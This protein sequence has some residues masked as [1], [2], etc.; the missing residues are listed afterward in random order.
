VAGQPIDYDLL[1]RKYGGVP[2]NQTPSDQAPPQGEPE[3]DYDALVR[4][5]GGTPVAPE[6]QPTPK[7]ADSL[8]QAAG[9]IGSSVIQ[10]GLEAG[11]QF[12]S[13]FLQTTVEPLASA[14]LHPI[15]TVRNLASRAIGI[16]ELRKMQDLQKAGDVAGAIKEAAKYQIEGPVGRLAIDAAKPVV[17]NARQGNYA[18]AAGNATGILASAYTPEAAEAGASAVKS[19]AQ[20]VTKVDPVSAMTK[21]LGRYAH[22]NFQQSLKT[23]M[24]EIKAAE[25]T[26]G[27]IENIDSLIDGIR[28]A[29][30]R[31]WNQYESLLGESQA[32][33]DGGKIADAMMGAI[34]D[35]TLRQKPNVV[36]Q[37]KRKADTYRNSPVYQ[38]LGTTRKLSIQEA[39]E[40]LHGAN[41]ELDTYY[42]KNPAARRVS[43]KGDPNV[44]AV[45]AE[46]DA[47]RNA[48]YDAIDKGGLPAE[49]KRKYG[50]LVD[51]EQ[52]AYRRKN[53]ATAQ[54]FDDLSQQISKW[55]AVGRMVKGGLTFNLPEFISG[56][57]EILASKWLKEQQA[58]NGLIKKAFQQL[59]TTGSKSSSLS[60]APFRALPAVTGSA[61]SKPSVP[62]TGATSQP[63]ASDVTPV[64]D[65]LRNVISRMNYGKSWDELAPNERTDVENEVNKRMYA[66]GGVI[67]EP[68]LG[69]VGE[70]GPEAIVPVESL[71][72]SKQG[73]QLLDALPAPEPPEDITAAKPTVP[74]RPE[75]IKAQLKQL[76]ARKRRVVML[77]KGT[78]GI[79]PKG[80]KLFRDEYGNRY[81]YHPQLITEGKIRKAIQTNSLPSI[82]GATK[83]GMGAPDKSQLS[84]SIAVVGRTRNGVTTQATATDARHLATTIRQVKK[85]TPKGGK[86]S[87]E[88]PEI[89]IRRRISPVSGI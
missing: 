59:G 31:I 33:I 70:Q 78:P 9:K 15:D 38:I 11:K 47:L 24:P 1:V 85:L 4:K 48:I 37:I 65:A 7:T 61:S 29:K 19:A 77:P 87:I 80:M 12:G 75:T 73:Q 43:A 5:F 52:Q 40:Y 64:A 30:R 89:E 45:A 27:P 86:V 55:S 88:P 67:T 14:I 72:E 56:G 74:E 39:E 26:I 63:P 44:A 51:L 46:A 36:A 84:E 35:R 23:A 82:L 62:E 34:D 2:V 53:M 20:S 25:Q 54:M 13:G 32:A 66:K 79:V 69:I 3:S 8:M 49:L 10:Q 42:A 17:E 6:N 21:A 81:I 57:S 76:T 68:T 18:K 41:A 28:L 22:A 60:T 71:E 83:N 50:A 16:D 58:I